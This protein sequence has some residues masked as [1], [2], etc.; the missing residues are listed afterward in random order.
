M[1]WRDT[2][3]GP[4]S[5]MSKGEGTSEERQKTNLASQ[6]NGRAENNSEMGIEHG[7]LEHDSRK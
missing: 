3:E 6:G 7:E 5:H 2:V 4:R 1:H